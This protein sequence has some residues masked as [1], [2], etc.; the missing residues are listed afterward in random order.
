MTRNGA[1]LRLTARLIARRDALRATLEQDLEGFGKGGQRNRGGDNIDAAVDSANA[2]ICSQIV[3]LETTEL[4]RIE[5]ALWRIKMGKYGQ[6][7]VCGGRISAARLSVLPYTSTCINCQ[8]ESE[9]SRTTWAPALA[10]PRWDRV[11]DTPPRGSPATPGS[12]GIGFKS[13]PIREENSRAT[14]SNHPRC[15][16]LLREL[17]GGL[18]HGLFARRREQDPALRALRRRPEWAPE[19]PVYHEPADDPVPRRPTRR[20]P[21]RGPEAEVERRLHP[22]RIRSTSSTRRERETPR[23]KSCEWRRR[24]AAT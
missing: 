6:C 11:D 19:G 17:E 16:R 9:R 21:S 2:D 3:E 12:T 14:L 15:G 23:K 18:S 22:A 7:E 1:L 13:N 8:R 24:P 5:H 4:A 10:A 20:I